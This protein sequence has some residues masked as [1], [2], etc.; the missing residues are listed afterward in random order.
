MRSVANH[1]SIKGGISL[2]EREMQA[3]TTDLFSCEQPNSTPSGRP[4]YVEFK[5]EALEK[6]F[7]R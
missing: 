1:Q 5:K 3:L 7:G 4:V 2:T 6:M